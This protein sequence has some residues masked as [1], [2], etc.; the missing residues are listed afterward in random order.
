MA[1]VS[2]REFLKGSVIGA[3]GLAA[4]STG[5]LPVLAEEEATAEMANG[6]MW[7]ADVEE[8]ADVVVVGAGLSGLAAAAQAAQ[9]GLKVVVLECNPFVGGNGSG[10]EGTFGMNS[11]LQQE[12]GITFTLAEILD[13]ELAGSQYRSNGLLWKDFIL[14]SADNISWLMD[15]G[16]EFSGEVESYG[17]TSGALTFHWFK[18]HTASVGYINQMEACVTDLGAEIKLSCRARALKLD[19]GAVAG[20]FAEQED[21][22]VLL[23][24]AKAVILASG[25]FGENMDLVKNLSFNSD[26]LYYIGTKGHLGDGYLMAM[27]AGAKSSIHTATFNANSIIMAL[28]HD[29]PID[30][31]N[32]CVG[33]GQGGPFLW[34]NQDA[35]RYVNENLGHA[36]FELQTVPG[37]NQ[38][39][40]YTVFDSKIFEDW[41]A[42]KGLNYDDAFAEIEYGLENNEEESFYSADTIEELAEKIGLDPEA[43]AATVAR[44]NELCDLGTDEDFGKPADQMQKIATAPYYIGRV[45]TEL[46]FSCGGI[47]TNRKYE[48]IKEDKTPI[49]GLYAVGNDGNM[50]YRNVYTIDVPGTCSAS[51]IHG[52]RTA[53]NE[54]AAYIGMM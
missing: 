12:K 22:T 33:I 7:T 42:A 43:L 44:Y 48:V 16:V 45:T 10:V 47:A 40:I 39:A 50:L 1:N 29:V 13:A 36:N 6:D 53:A 5:V 8:E 21:G 35:E 32:G 18:G 4:L 31:V 11:V 41:C 27:E 30:P 51:G 52:A 14:G 34:V 3:A 23:V 20:I 26:N 19:D 54:A 49:P 17:T 28:P 37:C 24:N 15:C 9:N 46:L 2:R 38:D 25:G